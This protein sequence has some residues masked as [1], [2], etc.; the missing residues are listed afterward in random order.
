VA[1]RPVRR[2]VV[3]GGGLAGAKAVETL[4]AEGFDGAL[5]LLGAEPRRPYE[6]PPLSKGYLTGDQEREAVFVHPDGWYA[7]HDVD[8]RVGTPVRQLDV[9]AHQVVTDAGEQLGYDRLLLATG[10]APRRLPLPGADGPAVAYLRTLADSD[11]LRTA[12]TADARVVIIGGGWIGLE[13]AAAARGAG[14]AVTVLEAGPVPLGRVLGAE[15]GAVFRDLHLE[16]GVDLRCDVTVTGVTSVSG[17]AAVQLGD[18]SEVPADVVLIGVGAR[19]NERL[20]ADAGLAVDNGVLVDAGLR[21]SHP[22][23]Y[24]AGD[25]ANAYHP[26]L[27]RHIR[28][29]HWANA[30]HQGPAAA[31]SILGQPVSYD[32]VP[33]F[34]T[35]QYDLGMEYSGLAGPGDF[36]EVVVR[37]DVAARQFIAY[38]L[39]DGR[40]LAGMNVNTWDVAERIQELIRTAAPLDDTALLP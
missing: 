20:A 11:R 2:V 40:V 34:Y 38:W 35:D 16:H 12:F 30:L 3:V 19:P 6:R 8:L 9:A 18:G 7:E 14:A 26:L 24:A 17:A 21:T 39:R 28:V 5:V 22:D 32:R 1:D 23:V 13:A 33:Y 36:D 27:G 31:R 25:V 37:G 15:M 4:R 29:E 10:S